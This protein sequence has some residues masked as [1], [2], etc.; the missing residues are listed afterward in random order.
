MSDKNQLRKTDKHSKKVSQEKQKKPFRKINYEEED[1]DDS[2]YETIDSNEEDDTEDQED[3][4]QE[5]SD[6]EDEELDDIIKAHKLHKLVSELFPSKYSKEKV[7][8]GKKL[9]NSVS[10]KT[11]L[12]GN[13]KKKENDDEDQDNESSD[14]FDKKKKFNIIFNISELNDEYNSEYESVQD[15]DEKNLEEDSENEEKIFMKEV[16]QTPPKNITI[17]N[18]NLKEPE[19]PKKE[20][21]SKFTK[22]KEHQEKDDVINIEEEYAQL[23]EMKKETLERLEKNP[24]NKYYL[25]TLSNI[26]ED[27]K[28]LIKMGRKKNTKQFYKLINSENKKKSELEYFE[29]NLSHSEQQKIVNEL[30]VINDSLY[31]DKPYRLA[32]LQSKMPENVKAVALQRLNMIK[33]MEPGDPEYFKLK[34][35][36]DAFLKIP[37]GQHKSLPVNINDG[38]EACH[39]FMEKTHNILNECTYGM[40]EAKMQVMQ[41]VG[42][43][44][45]NP[46][47]IGNAVALKGPPGSGKTSIIKDGI[48]KILGRDF[49]FI[50]LGGCAD[51]SYLE[52]NSYVYEGSSYGKIIQSIIQCQSMN[53]VIYFDEL[54]KVS[55]SPRGQEIIGVLTH[56]TDTTQNSQFHDKYFS[57]IHFDLSK[58]LFMFSYN[59]ESL[60]NPILKDRMYK[61]MTNGYELKEKIIIGQKY[62]IPKIL[63]QIKFTPEDIIIPDNVLSYIAENF[64]QKEEGVRNLKRCLEIIYTKLNLFRLVKPNSTTFFSKQINISITFPHTVTTHDVDV[65]IKNEINKFS[66]LS[67]M[68]I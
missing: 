34:N 36:V 24:N 20:K 59:D 27:I 26:K 63:H 66:A 57:E 46:D 5:D 31:V 32:V 21:K 17:H 58:C 9:L 37:F 1:E 68:Y 51:G 8:S 4:D 25:K 60:I 14:D 33:Q 7:N 50:P 64:T 22:K 28:I 48:S 52:G 53:P 54:D 40:T 15:H 18:C 55:D 44:L 13:H 47:A 30:K 38:I 67:S 3:S 62:V 12:K 10:K 16:Y 43:W 41:L 2:D 29:K 11:T 23:A 61:I 56:L 6:Q 19:P 35:W 65:L 45:T 49:I 39:E 42:Q